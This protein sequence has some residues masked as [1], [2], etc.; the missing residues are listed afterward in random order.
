[1]RSQLAEARQVIAGAQ[2][3]LQDNQ[4]AL[5]ETQQALQS[6][7]TRPCPHQ[8]EG[9]GGAPRAAE[10]DGLL[11]RQAADIE[12]LRGRLTE[13]ERMLAETRQALHDNQRAL[14]DTRQELRDAQAASSGPRV[15]AGAPGG[16]AALFDPPPAVLP[17]VALAEEKMSLDPVD[18]Y[19]FAV[20]LML[21]L[22]EQP[23]SI[24]RRQ[25]I[26]AVNEVVEK[27]EGAFEDPP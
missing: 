3:A 8:Q 24:L 12:A 1:M 13:S 25:M 26:N 17:L 27:Y 7:L 4:R 19:T 18:I 9:P 21:H 11:A 6:A 2:R 10:V 14:A 15:G 16:L 23:K 5:V 22:E 20:G